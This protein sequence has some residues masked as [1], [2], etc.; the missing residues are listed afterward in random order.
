MVEGLE[1]KAFLA[2]RE[3][4]KFLEMSWDKKKPAVGNKAFG[5]SA[6]S[7][8]YSG[9]GALRNLQDI[10]LWKLLEG[11]EPVSDFVSYILK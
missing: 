6:G 10:V 1:R 7:H 11:C 3:N 8:F 2:S 5:A 4:S 9:M